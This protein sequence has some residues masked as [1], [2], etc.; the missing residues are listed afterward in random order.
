MCVCVCVC[1][2]QGLRVELGSLLK[3][4]LRKTYVTNTLFLKHT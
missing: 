4:A 2:C 3:L 1:V